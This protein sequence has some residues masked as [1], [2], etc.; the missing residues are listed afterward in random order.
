M[1]RPENWTTKH[2]FVFVREDLSI[3]QQTVQAAHAAYEAG[4]RFGQ[5]DG[6][7][8]SI[9]ICVAQNSKELQKI[10]IRLGY[11]NI[12]HHC[13]HEP[14]IP[15]DKLTAIGTESLSKDR[16][17]PLRKYRL[18]MNGITTDTVKLRNALINNAKL[19]R[20]LGKIKVHYTKLLTEYNAL[21]REFNSREAKRV[22]VM[23]SYNKGL[24]AKV[25]RLIWGCWC[26][27]IPSFGECLVD[28][29]IGFQHIRLL[30]TK[31]KENQYANQRN[32]R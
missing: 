26:I 23:P 9:V 15:N 30:N 27:T 11:L 24:L 6:P 31:L 18:W 1:Q 21:V 10:S 22:Q 2:F 3:E 32:Y 8:G 12:K 19:E 13:F 14:D 16:R 28:R 4:I 7:Y 20:K 5:A 17:K 25:S 29:P